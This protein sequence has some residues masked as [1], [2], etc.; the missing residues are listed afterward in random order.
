[1][2]S[3]QEALAQVPV[4]ALTGELR[5]RKRLEHIDHWPCLCSIASAWEI[6]PADLWITATKIK[7]IEEARIAALVGLVLNGATPCAA[8]HIFGMTQ[9]AARYYTKQHVSRMQES[10]YARRF[11]S[12]MA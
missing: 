6:D 3:L 5:R 1:M 7:A 10:D 4:A 8:A 11:T 2:S 12:A 9:Q